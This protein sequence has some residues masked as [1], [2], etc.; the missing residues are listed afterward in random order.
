MELNIRK[1]QEGDYEEILV[2]WWKDWRW[3]APPKDFL[4]E[5]GLGGLIVYAGDIPVCAGFIYLTNSKVSWCDW[6]ISNFHYREKDT[7]K[8]AIRLLIESMNKLASGVGSKYL[9]ALI[10]NN[11]LIETYEELGYV[12]GSKYNT[13]LIKKV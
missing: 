1:L 2:G 6:I 7:R 3:D 13:E 4:P 10:K 9:Y 5:D 12:Q 8:Q 11:S